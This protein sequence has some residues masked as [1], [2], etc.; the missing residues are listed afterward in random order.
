[1]VAVSLLANVEPR[2]ER[3]AHRHD[4]RDATPGS[5]DSRVD[6]SLP[7]FARSAGRWH[8]ALPCPELGAMRAFMASNAR[9]SGGGP[10]DPRIAGRTGAIRRCLSRHRRRSRR[11]G[12]R[13]VERITAASVGVSSSAR[14]S[15]R[16]AGLRPKRNSWSSRPVPRREEKSRSGE[17]AAAGLS[18]WFEL[19]ETGGEREAFSGTCAFGRSPERSFA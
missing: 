15:A 1:V 7:S 11:R 10:R 14:R 12:L 13:H 6:E 17:H 4:G 9:W 16:A 8:P 3:C 19:V 5:A 2:R 18:G